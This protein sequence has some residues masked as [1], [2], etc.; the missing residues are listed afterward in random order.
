VRPPGGGALLQDTERY[1]L[2]NRLST[3]HL[4]P[5]EYRYIDLDS[6][7]SKQEAIKAWEDYCLN[8]GEG[9]TPHTTAHAPAR[10][11]THAHATRS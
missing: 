1:K 10:T 8:G 7:E 4:K 9:E 3:E 6:Q 11:R 2:I 5:V